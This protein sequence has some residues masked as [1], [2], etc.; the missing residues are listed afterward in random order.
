VLTPALHFARFG[1][2]PSSAVVALLEYK[3]VVI[4]LYVL[5]IPTFWSVRNVLK[6]MGREREAKR[7]GARTVPW[8]RGKWPGNVDIMLRWV[9][10]QGERRLDSIVC[11]EHRMVSSMHGGY[12]GEGEVSIIPMIPI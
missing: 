4:G 1:L 2:D 11:D 6:T 10:I 8:V 5:A 7:M 9:I 3:A 12:V